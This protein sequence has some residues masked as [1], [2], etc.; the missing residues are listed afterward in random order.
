MEQS[1]LLNSV[2]FVAAGSLAVLGIVGRRSYKRK[3][4]QIAREMEK[5]ASTVVNPPPRVWAVLTPGE[6]V[7]VFALPLGVVMAGTAATGY[8]LKR[9]Y[10][11]RDARDA[12]DHIRWISRTGPTPNSYS[13]RNS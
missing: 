2:G 3:V 9:W 1:D 10:G 11:F 5:E 8:G 13:E 12:L 4:V 6:T 7:K